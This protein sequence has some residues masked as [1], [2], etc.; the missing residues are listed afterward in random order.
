MLFSDE[1]IFN[2]DGIFNSKNDRIWAPTREQADSKG[3]LYQKSKFTTKVMV[4]MAA[5]SK[6]GITVHVIKEATLKHTGY[7][8]Q[9]LPRARALG[10]KEFGRRWWF[11]QDNATPHTHKKCQAWCREKLPK[12][13]DKA[14]WPP[15]SPDLNPCDYGLWAELGSRINWA[16]V[17]SKKTLVAQ[18]RA[19]SRKVRRQVVKDTCSKWGLR[20]R[21]LLCS[22]GN[23]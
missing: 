15:N 10:R 11:Q 1:K 20:L 16:T 5:S 13:F 6:G 9:C 7:L 8:R 17:H 14:R 2:V 4:W 23:S 3:G 21:R 22:N 19:A 12:F 18:I